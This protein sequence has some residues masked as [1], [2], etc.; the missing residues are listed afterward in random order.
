MLK[1]LMPVLSLIVMSLGL[2]ACGTGGGSAGGGAPPG[3]PPTA[4]RSD[5]PSPAP[6]VAST[7]PDRVDTP[8][9]DVLF[10]YTYHRADGN[11]LVAGSGA[12]PGAE[13]VDVPLDGVPR[14]VVGAPVE[15]GSLWAVTLTDG[16]VRGFLAHGGV[17]EDAAITPDSLP[18]DA[19][20]LLRVAADGTATFVTPP[21]ET[22]SPLTHPV[23]LSDGRI[24]FVDGNGDLVFWDGGESAR[25]AVGALPDARILRDEADRLLLLTGP[26]TRYPHG[27]LGD[28]V[29]AAAVTL[30]ETAPEPRIARIIS[31]PGEAVIEGIAP[32]WADLTGDGARKIVVTLSDAD[33]GAR[34]AV[35]DESGVQVAGGPAVGQGFR[36]RHQI[37]VAPF[38]PSGEVE[39]A[40]VLT[41]HIGGTVEFFRLNGGALALAAGVPG[42]TSH[43][44]HTRNLD[45]S[46][47][48]DFDG[49]GAVELLVLNPSRTELTAIAR[50]ER[51]AAAEWTLPL[52]GELATNLA[53]VET[54]DGGIALAAG[55]ADRVLRL[56]PG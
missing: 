37:A 5:A 29:E 45:L 21:L 15:G 35:F 13:P 31:A 39:L 11:R 17:V 8:A 18:P 20:P 10:G 12:L 50:T 41:P 16:R 46:L 28:E 30:V 6:A 3:N 47:A 22:A 19:P 34:L 48:G 44:I 36:W 43:V 42:Y 4:T 9:G 27:A 56:W 26:T 38:G 55:R 33:Q 24:A 25:L 51:G 23:A 2:F 54:A 40:D 1:R 7:A 53:A 32:I 52:G 14:W 49:D